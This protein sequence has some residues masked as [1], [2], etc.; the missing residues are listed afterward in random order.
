MSYSGGE[1]T[2]YTQYSAPNNQ[3]ATTYTPA[4]QSQNQ[5]GVPPYNPHTAPYQQNTTQ[6]TY[7]APYGQSNVQGGTSYAKSGSYGQEA[8]SHQHSN[9][10]TSNNSNGS[11]SYNQAPPPSFN[12]TSPPSF[13]Q[14]PPPSF[15][16]TS[17]P[18]FNQAPPP[19]FNQTPPPLYNHTPAPNYKENTC[20]TYQQ[21]S[22]NHQAPGYSQG[23]AC[24]QQ[25]ISYP[26]QYPS[27]GQQGPSCTPGTEPFSQNTNSNPTTYG[28]TI[29]PQKPPK[30]PHMPPKLQTSFKQA[31]KTVAQ[32]PQPITSMQPLQ[33]GKSAVSMAHDLARQ[34]G[35]TVNWFEESETGPPHAKVFSMKVTMGPYEVSGSARSKKLAKQDAAQLLVAQVSG[36]EVADIMKLPG[37]SGNVGQSGNTSEE[38]GPQLPQTAAQKIVSAG[39][40]GGDNPISMLD[41]IVKKHKMGE[42]QYITINENG[43]LALQRFDIKVKVGD[44][45][46]SGLGR[47]KKVAK[48]NAAQAMLDQLSRTQAGIEPPKKRIMFVK[49]SSD[50]GTT[51][52]SSN[53]AS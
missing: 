9:T 39:P 30:R 28:P 3:F 44:K 37:F 2:P 13:N 53:S 48:R 46:A 7:N 10:A 26:Q 42:P 35:W 43:P 36:N 27:Y 20:S 40:S 15:N 49:A 22:F 8:T 25:W 51:T 21:G 38:Y 41:H 14:A 50:T 31:K 19:S 18:S 29:G 47:S 32:P 45:E 12:Q 6:Y 4:N 5:Y 33:G 1:Y 16:Q 34:N 17:P 11:T 24:P 52:G 23:P